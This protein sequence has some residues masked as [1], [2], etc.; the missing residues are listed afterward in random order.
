M[1]TLAR[2]QTDEVEA[3]EVSGARMRPRD[4]ESEL[5]DKMRKKKIE[6]E[7][8]KNEKKETKE[9]IG[10]YVSSLINCVLLVLTLTKI[11]R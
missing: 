7:K 4:S 8:E 9:K 11:A 6:K 10:Y 5:G 2:L 3:L 1:A